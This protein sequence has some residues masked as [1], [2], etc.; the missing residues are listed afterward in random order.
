MNIKTFRAKTMQQALDLVRQELGPEATVLHTRE[1][2]GG[3][4]RRFL[5]GTAI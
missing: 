2:N 3:L 1:V 5:L 4:V